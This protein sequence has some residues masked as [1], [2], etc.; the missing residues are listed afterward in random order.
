MKSNM[1]VQRHQ[2]IRIQRLSTKMVCA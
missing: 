2:I 1:H